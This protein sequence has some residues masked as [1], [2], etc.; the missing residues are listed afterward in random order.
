MFFFGLTF[1]VCILTSE[2]LKKCD[3]PAKAAAKDEKIRGS[4]VQSKVDY[5]M[6]KT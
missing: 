3:V 4:L 5:I 2:H 1:L 6:D